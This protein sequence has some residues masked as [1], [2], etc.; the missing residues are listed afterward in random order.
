MKSQSKILI[1]R[2]ESP[3]GSNYVESITTTIFR[4]VD[5]LKKL[6]IPTISICEF[7]CNLLHPLTSKVQSK[8]CLR[9]DCKIECMKIEQIL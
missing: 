8:L 9:N 1:A 7:G 2:N 3:N 4:P 6:V 5:K